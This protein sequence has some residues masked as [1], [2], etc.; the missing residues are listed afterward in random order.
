MIGQIKGQMARKL[1][2]AIRRQTDRLFPTRETQEYR[3]WIAHR[4][5]ARQAFYTQPLQPGLLSVM[6]AVWDGSPLRYLKQLAQ[7]ISAQNENGACEWVIADNGC[8]K[9]AWRKYLAELSAY[10]W[11]KIV[12]SEKNIGIIGGLR[13]CLKHARARYVLPVDA[14]DWIYPDALKAVTWALKNAHYPA[15]LFTDEDKIAGKQHYQPYMKPGWDPVLLLNS[16]YIAHLAAVDRE[17]ALEL[18]AYDDPATEASPDWDLFVRFLIAGV[19]AAH[20]PDIVYSWRVHAQS[21]ADDAAAK[22]YVGRSQI[23]VLQRHVDAMS[24]GEDLEVLNSP[25][26]AGGPHWRILSRSAGTRSFRPI[27]FLPGTNLETVAEAARLAAQHGDFLQLISGDVEIESADWQSEVTTL[28]QLHPDIVMIGGRIHNRKGTITSAGQYFGVCGI[29]GCPY[30][31]RPLEHP[32]YFAQ[33]WKRRSVSAVNTQFAVIDARF[34]VETLSNIPVSASLPF[35]G[36]WIGAEAWRR[37]KRVVYSPFLSAM[38]DTDW[39]QLFPTAEQE[40]FLQRNRDLIPDHRFYSP[41]LSLT[42]GFALGDA[43]YDPA[44]P[45]CA[46]PFS[47]GVP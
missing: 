25:F 18:G 44:C 23:A 29:C 16:A 1:K 35:L 31:G 45:G 20:L 8:S 34:L 24:G 7:A 26:L 2:G 12:R 39:E 19:A 10:K 11:V 41:A 38:S 33:L 14:D 36:A 43:A 47:E 13:L 37:R 42:K 15:L 6:T 27:R 28:T 46:T 32:G 4:L 3:K 30:R 21:T 40:L 9:T 22:S 17:K 5:A